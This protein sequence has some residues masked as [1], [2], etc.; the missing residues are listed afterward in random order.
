[1]NLLRAHDWKPSTDAEGLSVLTFHEAARE[2]RCSR[3]FIAKITNGRIHGIP[4]LAL[5]PHRQEA[6]DTQA[7][8]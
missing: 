7:A 4:P 6:P 5:L 2:L 1:M 8:A 3:S